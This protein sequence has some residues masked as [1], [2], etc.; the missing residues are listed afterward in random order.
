MREDIENLIEK[1]VDKSFE[2]ARE[3]IH[4]DCNSTKVTPV[5][6]GFSDSGTDHCMILL[7]WEDDES[8]CSMLKEL[9]SK[10][11]EE[12]L[13][14]VAFI[15]DAVMKSYSKKPDS[16]T[17]MP[18]TFPPNERIDCLILVH[19]DFKDPKE[20]QFN[21]Y[22]YK[23]VDGNIAREKPVIYNDPSSSMDSLVM[24]CI[25]YGF[26]N[27]ATFDEYLKREILK[28][29]F[30]KEVGKVLLLAVLEKYPGAA[31]GA[32]LK[33]NEKYPNS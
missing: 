12:N 29:S 14:S 24:S 7:P 30:T 11:Y 2:V 10:C 16:I 21:V 4:K 28:E 17:E 18:L 31:L 19:I 8:K 6:F 33:I 25:A 23:I 5:A 32:S 9:G 26:L 3:S 27:A 20:N 22:P 13:M 1:F 15:C